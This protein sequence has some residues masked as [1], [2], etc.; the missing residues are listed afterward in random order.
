LAAIFSRTDLIQKKNG[1]MPIAKLKYLVANG[2]LATRNF[3]PCF[4]VMLN[5]MLLHVS[6]YRRHQGAHTI[7]TSTYISVCITG[8]I[9]EY[10]VK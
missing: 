7:L 1:Q 8:E 10:R 5:Q 3:A 4:I 6:A 2:N 9:M